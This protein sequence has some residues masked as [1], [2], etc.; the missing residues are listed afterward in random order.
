MSFISFELDINQQDF[1]YFLLRELRDYIEKVVQRNKNGVSNEIRKEVF[2]K[3]LKSDFYGQFTKG[4]MYYEI[5]N[6]RA[7]S[8]LKAI[9]RLIADNMLVNFP[10]GNVGNGQLQIDIEIGILESTYNDILT[11]PHASYISI[12]SSGKR[13]LIEWMK[14]LLISGSGP[15]VYNYIFDSHKDYA[16]WSRT[17]QG[18]MLKSNNNTW[19]LRQVWVGKQGDNVL[20]RS[21]E[22]IEMAIATIL[23]LKIISKL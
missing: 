5:G 10:V 3:L 22:G 6:N 4:P 19:G 14:W 23:D 21:L 16:Q 11:S 1:E 12:N 13:T 20:T 17:G 7:D 15:L 18:L 9:F 2:T 8:D